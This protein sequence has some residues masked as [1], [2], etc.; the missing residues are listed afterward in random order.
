M[1]IP[2]ITLREATKSMR[3]SF[4]VNGRG[5]VFECTHFDSR[6]TVL[7]SVKTGKSKMAKTATL[8]RYY[9]RAE[10]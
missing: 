2:K 7:R 1:N 9:E 10:A 5:E 4:V 8:N 3:G 6:D